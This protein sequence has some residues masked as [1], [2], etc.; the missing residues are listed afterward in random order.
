MK[1]TRAT[2]RRLCR[3]PLHAMDRD[4][5]S[6]ELDGIESVE[7]ADPA[8]SVTYDLRVIRL[9]RIAEVLSFNAQALSL[10]ERMGW[11]WARIQ[12]CVH[13]D[14]LNCAGGWDTI[15]QAI[16]VSHYRPR[17]PSGLAGQGPR[18]RTATSQEYDDG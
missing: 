12:E 9:G 15:V 2:G 11:M 7:I 6:L 8:V 13:F 3:F 5:S 4:P 17:D 18:R 16:Y 14:D 1:N 10:I